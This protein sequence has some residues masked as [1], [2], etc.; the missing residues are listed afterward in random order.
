MVSDITAAQLFPYRPLDD[1]C[2]ASSRYSL[3]TS[4]EEKIE[5]IE[6]EMRAYGMSEFNR[7][8]TLNEADFD[9]YT[10]EV[11]RERETERRMRWFQ[12]QRAMRIQPAEHSMMRT[13]SP[14]RAAEQEL[15]SKRKQINER[16]EGWRDDFALGN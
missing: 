14:F 13:V 3:P 10:P 5:D 2:Q 12:S 4:K 1:T 16:V 8:A 7:V 15:S 6:A 11:R 9:R